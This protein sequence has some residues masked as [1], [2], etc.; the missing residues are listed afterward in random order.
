[1][2]ALA[3]KAVLEDIRASLDNNI[4]PDPKVFDQVDKEVC[5]KSL[6]RRGAVRGVTLTMLRPLDQGINENLLFAKIC[7]ASRKIEYTS[8]S[9]ENQPSVSHDH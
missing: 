9:D 7:Q 5:L 4:P 6:W 2:T 3:R 1:M 8:Y